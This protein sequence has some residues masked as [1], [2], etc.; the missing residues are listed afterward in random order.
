MSFGNPAQLFIGSNERG[1]A[2][3]SVLYNVRPSLI[4][5]G[6]DTGEGSAVGSFV[7]HS[8]TFSHTDTAGTQSVCRVGGKNKY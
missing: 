3:A 5:A 6:T 4:G 7:G 8:G 2:A 1:E